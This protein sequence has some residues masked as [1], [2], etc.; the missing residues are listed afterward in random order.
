MDVIDVCHNC[1][2]QAG[3]LAAAGVKTVIRYY[4]RDTAMPA[5]RLSLKEA[6]ALAAA[7]L[8]LCV[9][10]EARHGDRIGSFSQDLGVRDAAYALRFAEKCIG[11]PRGTA[12]YFAV[13]LDARPAEISER[14][15][16]YF[17]G[18]GSVL[19]PDGGTPAY[20]VGVYGSG[21][22]CAALLDL[23]LAEL[24]WLAQSRGWSGYKDFLQS[25]RWALKQ[26]MPCRVGEVRCDP[27]AV[28]AERPDFGD[29]AL[30]TG[31]DV[32]GPA[33]LTVIARSGL[34]LRSGPGTGFDVMRVMPFATRVYPIRRGE[35]WTL[36][37]LDGDGRA[38][39]FASSHFL[40]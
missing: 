33:A 17:R 19:A 36:V 32:S 23:G 12:I 9:V 10:H 30:E 1:E 38:D 39:G 2:T 28:N 21:V 29:F 7:D 35:D 25:K 40:A 22:V 24:A 18:V 5:K 11:Q 14:V 16:P 20:R 26:A 15:I 8:R 27:N 31:A 13:D 34:R 3:L 37:D 4:S 6:R